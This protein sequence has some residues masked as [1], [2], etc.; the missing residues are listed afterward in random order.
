MP[1]ARSDTEIT[2]ADPTS[3]INYSGLY[4]IEDIQ[5]VCYEIQ[6]SGFGTDT[7]NNADRTGESQVYVR[8]IDSNN[9]GI[10]IRIKKA[11]GIVEVQIA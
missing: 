5:R 11:G 9:D 8:N 3:D 6:S 7:T 4:D 2:G 1:I 10:F